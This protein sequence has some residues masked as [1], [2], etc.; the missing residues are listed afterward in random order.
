MSNAPYWRKVLLAYYQVL[1]GEAAIPRR[2]RIRNSP[3]G[4]RKPLG[5]LGRTK[6]VMR[7]IA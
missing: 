5:K 3:S 4:S 1:G 2:S 6:K 7:L